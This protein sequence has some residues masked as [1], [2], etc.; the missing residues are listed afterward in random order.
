MA[1]TRRPTGRPR[2]A[3]SCAFLL[4][5]AVAAASNARPVRAQDDKQKLVDE[6]S[7]RGGDAHIDEHER[8]KPV[9]SLLLCG[10][11]F[12]DS[13][14]QRYVRAFPKLMTVSIDSTAITDDGLSALKDSTRLGGLGLK[15]SSV[16]GSFLAA[17]TDHPNLWRL[18]MV[19][20]RLRG[21]ALK[22]LAAMPNLRAA[23]LM[24]RG[25]GDGDLVQLSGSRLSLLALGSPK[26]SGAALTAVQDLP[27]LHE[28]RMHE[29][30]LRDE[31]APEL[32]GFNRLQS[33][34]LGGEHVTD[35]GIKALT[36]LRQLR[37]VELVDT[38][39]TE[40]GVEVLKKALPDARII[41]RRSGPGEGLTPA[42]QKRAPAR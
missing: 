42:A 41:L 15:S 6:I 40:A 31:L 17:L 5:A 29:I 22:H 37:E 14:L 1:R 24:C 36:R 25:L 13:D 30:D 34:L 33:L 10:A 27:N 11:R 8:G 38:S 12:A 32:H 4:L 35:R 28:L 9:L 23:I 3:S 2:T 20:P 21:A 18:H 39:V 7:R 26:F 19:C 16:D